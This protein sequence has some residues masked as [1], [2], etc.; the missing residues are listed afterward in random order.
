MM[1]IPTERKLKNTSISIAQN[2]RARTMPEYSRFP[3]NSGNS[4]SPR[5]MG[6]FL[7]FKM[8]EGNCL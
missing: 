2:Q 4:V 1:I 6:R 5:L 8:R 3:A 7:S